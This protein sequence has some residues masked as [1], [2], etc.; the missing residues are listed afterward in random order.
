MNDKFLLVLMG[1][2]ADLFVPALKTGL[3]LVQAFCPEYV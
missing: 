3:V 1:L 2:K